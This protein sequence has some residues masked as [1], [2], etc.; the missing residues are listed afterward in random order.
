MMRWHH[1]YG[2]GSVFIEN[3]LKDSPELRRSVLQWNPLWLSRHDKVETHTLE[4]WQRSL[5]FGLRAAKEMQDAP[6]GPGRTVP[7][8]FGIDSIMATSP[9]ELINKIEADGFASRSFALAANLISGY[10]RSMPRQIKRYPVSIVGTNHLKPG[11]DYAGRPTAT[12][13]G[14]KSVKFMESYEIEMHRAPSPDIDKLEY[15]GLRLRMVARKNS[16]GP[17]RKQIVAELIWWYEEVDGT[18]RQQTAWDWDTATVELLLS[19]EAAKG[20]KTLYNRLQDICRIIP[21]SKRERKAKSP[22]L[23][24]HEDVEYR[25]IGAALEQRPDLMQQMYGVLGIL[26]RTAFQPGLDYQQLQA[27]ANAQARREAVNLYS[28]ADSM[29]I[30]DLD[31][32][33]PY[34][35]TVAP[36]DGETA[37]EVSNELDE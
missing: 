18:Y 22:T 13:P 23:G 29:P 17:S 20:K 11:T 9:E 5:T 21:K 36:S 2:G 25:E 12:I 19:F 34:G 31:V 33:D 15:G 7:I 35:I 30:A 10:M 16:L 32:M 8:I 4:E 6:G 14:G 27:E 26:P 1:V 3:E 24:I 37:G 28:R